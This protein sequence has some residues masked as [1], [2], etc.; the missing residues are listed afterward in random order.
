VSA[1]ELLSTGVLVVVALLIGGFS[2]YV[3]YKL[4]RS[5]S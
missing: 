3:V 5:H 2:L 1:V 4:Y